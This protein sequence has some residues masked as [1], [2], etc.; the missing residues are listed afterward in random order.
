[1]NW[2]GRVALLEEIKNAYPVL[3]RRLEEKI[4]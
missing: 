4:G 2:A 1:V 3:V